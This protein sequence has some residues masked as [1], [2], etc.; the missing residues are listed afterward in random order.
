[1]FNSIIIEGKTSNSQFIFAHKRKIVR[2]LVQESTQVM[3]MHPGD[4]RSRKSR[5]TLPAL[6][7]GLFRYVDCQKNQKH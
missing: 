2:L 5:Q 7:N 3:S 1:M 4:L 6:F